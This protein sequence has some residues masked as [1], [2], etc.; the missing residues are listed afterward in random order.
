MNMQADRTLTE[1]HYR[2]IASEALVGQ[3]T[4]EGVMNIID[5]IGDDLD[6]KKKQAGNYDAEMQRI[7][8]NYGL[9]SA[10]EQENIHDTLNGD[11]KDRYI[12]GGEKERQALLKQQAI[13]NEQKDLFLDTMNEIALDDK[14]GGLNNNWKETEIGRAFMELG[15]GAN[16]V[17][18]PVSGKDWGVNMPDFEVIDATRDQIHY[19]DNEINIL[20]QMYKQDGIYDDGQALQDLYDNRKKLTTTLEAGPIKWYSSQ[21]FSELAEKGKYDEGIAKAYQDLCNSYK[22]KGTNEVDQ[23]GNAIPINIEEVKDTVF[24]SIVS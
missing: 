5:S 23:H 9:P 8:D 3:A 19:L 20:E 14:H 22:I 17:L 6:F 7:L 12:N 18:D 10:A 4:H 2:A 1:G 13:M 15:N 24:G 21:A 11:M 16:L